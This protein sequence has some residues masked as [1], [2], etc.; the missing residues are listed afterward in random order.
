MGAER[1]EGDGGGPVDA[2]ECPERERHCVD[3][4]DVQLRFMPDRSDK[5][6]VV[7]GTFP[8]EAD[9]MTKPT[10]FASPLLNPFISLEFRVYISE[11][12]LIISNILYFVL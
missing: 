6:Q 1:T 10:P 4:D 9:A 3:V 8:L 7:L 2:A 5:V 12:S 11:R